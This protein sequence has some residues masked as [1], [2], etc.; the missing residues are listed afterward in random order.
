MNVA[1]DKVM[2]RPAAMRMD[3]PRIVVGL[4]NIFVVGYCGWGE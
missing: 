1:L 2:R 4:I 3:K